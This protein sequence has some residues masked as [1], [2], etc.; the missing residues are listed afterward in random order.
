MYVRL[1]ACVHIMRT[2]I[3]CVRY[4]CI[5]V[6][7]VCRWDARGP[8]PELIDRGRI[9]SQHSQGLVE[10]LLTQVELFDSKVLASALQYF[11]DR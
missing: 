5:C 8:D 3:V 9:H 7:A 1:Y 6:R 4:I 11:V 2:Y 10:M